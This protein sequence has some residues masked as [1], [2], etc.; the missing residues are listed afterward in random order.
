MCNT[1]RQNKRAKEGN[2]SVRQKW[3][4]MLSCVLCYLYCLGNAKANKQT[5]KQIKKT[6]NRHIQLCKLT[7]NYRKMHNNNNTTYL[8]EKTQKK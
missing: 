8:E 2:L 7:N 5:N 4:I 3:W 1:C 6:S